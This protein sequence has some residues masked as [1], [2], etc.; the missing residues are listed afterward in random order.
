MPVVPRSG[1]VSADSERSFVPLAVSCVCIQRG[2]GEIAK[3]DNKCMDRSLP[4]TEAKTLTRMWR[5]RFE[6]TEKHL[7]QSPTG[8]RYAMVSLDEGGMKLTFRAGVHRH[9]RVERARAVEA[10]ITHSTGVSSSPVAK[11]VTASTPRRSL[12]PGTVTSADLGAKSREKE[13]TRS[14]V[15]PSQLPTHHTCRLAFNTSRS[16]SSCHGK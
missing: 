11:Q 9:M 7:P 6:L 1:V 14:L 13:R 8:Q 2:K 15:R 16:P 5:R 12:H 4:A 3:R 10:F